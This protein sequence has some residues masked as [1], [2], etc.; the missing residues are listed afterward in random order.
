MEDFSGLWFDCETVEGTTY[1]E[2]CACEKQCAN[3]LVPFNTYSP[4]VL[5]NFRV[6][7]L[8][9]ADDEICL[10][11]E[12]HTAYLLTGIN[13]ALPSG[14]V[15]LDASRPW[16]CYW[17]LHALY[18]LEKEPIHLYPR[19]IATLQSMSQ[20]QSNFPLHSV[21]SSSPSDTDEKT[22]GIL[23]SYVLSY[24]TLSAPMSY[25]PTCISHVTQT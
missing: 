3:F 20:P 8:V 6:G 22:N 5:E 21:L 23:F 19:V 17:I 12:K 10:L 15:S 25:T 16:I 13:A 24:L 7:R 18:L 2:Q 11:R 14:F 4:E 9:N 1:E